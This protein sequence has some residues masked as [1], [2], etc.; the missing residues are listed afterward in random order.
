MELK[1]K[2]LKSYV[3]MTQSLVNYLEDYMSICIT[4]VV[5][6]Y[7]MDYHKIPW[8]LSIKSMRY[9]TKLTKDVKLTP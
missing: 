7:T 3:D 6:D 8:F 9:T 5:A 1:G 2:P 4:E